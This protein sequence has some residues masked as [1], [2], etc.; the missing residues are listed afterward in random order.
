MSGSASAMRI[1][2]Q[3]SNRI[4]FWIFFR[5]FQVFENLT[6]V[7]G[8]DSPQQSQTAS[9]RRL[10]FNRPKRRSRPQKRTN[11]NYTVDFNPRKNAVKHFVLYD[12]I[13]LCNRMS[14]QAVYSAGQSTVP[15]L[16]PSMTSCGAMPSIVQPT[17][18]AVPSTS[19]ITP[20][21]GKQSQ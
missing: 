19:F 15:S 11:S 16:I 2:L 17:D 18:W 4:H 21:V 5:R 7:S 12:F 10:D 14:W 3:Y 9:G 6:S 1:I 20:A 13:F 8:L